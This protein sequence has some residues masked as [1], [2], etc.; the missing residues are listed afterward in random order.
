MKVIEVLPHFKELLAMTSGYCP[1]ATVHNE[2]TRCPCK[3]FREQTTPG[4]CHCGRFEKVE[5]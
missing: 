1:C 3:D 2:D 4:L 5:E